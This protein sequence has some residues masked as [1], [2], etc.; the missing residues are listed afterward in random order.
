MQRSNWK[1]VAIEQTSYWNPEIVE[2]TGRLFGTFLFDA[3]RQVHCC[4]LTPSY[5]MHF[6]ETLAENM[7]DD[8]TDA[9]IRDA[10]IVG[11]NEVEYWH[12]HSV[13]SWPA[14]HF[15]VLG[16]NDDDYETDE[17]ELEEML[18]YVR[19]NQHAPSCIPHS[20]EA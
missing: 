18:E 17:E 19:C 16:P 2:K 20:V 10:D 8:E 12:C 7:I 1:I 4:E 14:D 15:V 3:S 5:E 9:M 13:D 11:Q 6:I